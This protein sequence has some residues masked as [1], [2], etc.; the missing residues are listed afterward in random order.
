MQI[1]V[2]KQEI[3]A[4]HIIFDEFYCTEL[5]I[6]NLENLVSEAEIEYQEFSDVKHDIHEEEQEQY[7]VDLRNL[8]DGFLWCHG[9]LLQEYILKILQNLSYFDSSS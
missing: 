4:N 9:V 7:F 8:V 1:V 6:I 2:V 5:R 3:V